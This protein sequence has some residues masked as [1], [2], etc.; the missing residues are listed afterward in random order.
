MIKK[1]KD[2]VLNDIYNAASGASYNALSSQLGYAMKMDANS[3]T[4][5]INDAIAA[6]VRAGFESLMSNIYSDTEFE[7]DMTLR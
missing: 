4:S 2:D 3:V 1:S 5:A 6:A 7:Q